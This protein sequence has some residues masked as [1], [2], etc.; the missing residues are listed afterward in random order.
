VT[1]PLPV[2]EAPAVIVSQ[3]AFDVAV[4]AKSAAFELTA[5]VRPV[6]PAPTAV[7]E[8]GETETLPARPLCVTVSVWP[9]IVRVPVRLLVLGLAATL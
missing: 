1:V 2:V 7:S 3:D 4:Q 5:T 8:E 9:P 6:T